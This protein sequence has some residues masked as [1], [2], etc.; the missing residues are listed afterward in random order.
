VVFASQASIR[1]ANVENFMNITSG[2][3]VVGPGLRLHPTWVIPAAPS[4]PTTALIGA[5]VM[6]REGTFDCFSMVITNRSPISTASLLVDI[7]KNYVS[8]FDAETRPTILGGGTFV[9]TAS[10][11]TKGFVSGDIFTVDLDNAGNSIDLTITGRTI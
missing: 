5:L 2:A 7:N 8:I 3:S 4:G 11:K 1:S 10:I 9:S 6:P